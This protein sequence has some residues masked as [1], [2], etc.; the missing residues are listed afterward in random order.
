VRRALSILRARLPATRRGVRL[1][2]LNHGLFAAAPVLGT[3]SLLRIY[4][5]GDLFASDFRRAYWPAARRVLHGA[6]PYLPASTLDV[7]SFVYPA[8]G[9]ILLAPFGWL[10]RD[11]AA[12]VFTLINIA[13]LLGAVWLLGV[14][15]WRPYGLVFLWL[16]VISAW[17][18]ANVTLP[19]ALGIALVWRHRDRPVVAGVIV[20]VLVSVKPFV[21]PLGVWLFAS[22]RWGALATAIITTLAVNVGAWAVVGFGEISHF[23]DLLDALTH[24]GELTGY[25]LVALGLHAGTGRT[26]AYI[27]QM[28]V[29]LLVT[30][31]CVRRAWRDDDVHG[32][33]ACVAMILVTTPVLWLHYFALLVVPIGLLNQRL[34]WAWA[35]PMAMW[36]CLPTE[37]PDGWKIAVALTATAF[38]YVWPRRPALGL[39]GISPPPAPVSTPA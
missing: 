39:G 8:L 25:S 11:V 31:E 26:A 18:T 23:R 17:E 36:V 5:G 7:H 20:A 30:R 15:D 35:L 37:N 2:A 29:A 16:P 10:D 28:I 1:A 22:R 38:V 24:R 33:S 14:R 32:F 4:A 13:S 34:S 9:A 19:L 3:A 12:S 6:S 27:G 21:W